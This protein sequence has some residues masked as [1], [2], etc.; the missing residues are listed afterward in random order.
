MKKSFDLGGNQTHDLRIK[1]TITLPTELQGWTE[2]VGDDLVGECVNTQL[3]RFFF[4][5]FLL[6][7]PLHVPLSQKS[8]QEDLTCS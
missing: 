3:V 5:I 8:A 6:F 2:K 4:I 7:Y 1:S